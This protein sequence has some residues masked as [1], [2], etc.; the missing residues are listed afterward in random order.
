MTMSERIREYAIITAGTFVIGAAVFFFLAPSRLAVG[1]AS[2]LAVVLSHFI[3][4]SLSVITFGLNALF[5]LLGFVLVGG[6]FGAKTVYT[7]L[8]MPLFL[9]LFEGIFPDFQSLTGEAFLDM[10]CYCF[11]VSIGLALLFSRNASSGG[12]DIAAK[13]L[14][15]YFRLELGRAMSAAGIAV[16]L[17]S[18]LC[19][20]AKTVIVSLIGTYLNGIILDQFLFEI[21]QKLKICIISERFEEIR[22]YIV[23]T[24]HSG[25]TVYEARGAFGEMPVHPELQVI[26]DKSEYAK[27]MPYLQKVDPHAFITV[28]KVKEM[29]YISKKR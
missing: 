8:L 7:S 27:L 6:E 3:P 16:A 24:L 17:L 14:N 12:L 23:D 11:V 9:R 2:G 13:I 28:Y 20:D 21:S 10:L 19:Y 18:A 4:L 22:H 1:S 15:K 25:A 5:L 29:P 26:V